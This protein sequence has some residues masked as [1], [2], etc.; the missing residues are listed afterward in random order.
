MVLCLVSAI[1]CI[2]PIISTAAAQGVDN[3]TISQHDTELSTQPKGLGNAEASTAQQVSNTET[4]RSVSIN[5]GDQAVLVPQGVA[6]F[7]V[8][9]MDTVL[10]REIINPIPGS[11][12][13]L[14]FRT[15]PGFEQ[16][17]PL[18]FDVSANA[19]EGFSRLIAGG[20]PG[21]SFQGP[22]V[23]GCEPPDP[24][25]AVGPFH[26]LMGINDQI[27]AADKTTG[28]TLWSVSW[29]SFFSS[30]Q[31]AGAAFTSD[32]KLFYDPVSQRFFATVLFIN[33]SGSKSW[34]MLAVSDSNSV[35]SSGVWT[36]WAFDPTIAAPNFFAD[37]PGFGYD[38]NAVYITSNM[39]SSII[40]VDMAVIPKQQLLDGVAN[41]TFTQLTDIRQSNG[42]RAFTI[43]PAHMFGTGNA[44]FASNTG[45][46][47]STIYFYR[48]NNPLGSPSLTKTSSSVSS[49]S[50]PPDASQSGGGTLIN[51]G[52]DRM[53]NV[54][55][56]N[57]RL[58]CAHNTNSGGLAAAR[59][60]EFDTT[61]WP[62]A[63]STV[64][65]GTI[66]GT[67]VHYYYPTIAVDIFNNAFIGFSR[68][69]SSEFA[70]AWHTSRAAGDPLGTMATPTLDHSGS[71][72]Y[73]GGRWGDYSGTVIDPDGVTFWTMQEFADNTSNNWGNWVSSFAIGAPDLTAPT[74]NP[75]QWEVGG[76]P[77][78]LSTTDIAMQAA[79]ATDDRSGVEYNFS[80]ETGPGA[81]VSSGWQSSVNFTDTGLLANTSYEYDVV[82][83]DMAPTPNVTLPSPLL[84]ATTSIEAPTFVF[85][86]PPAD[87]SVGITAFTPTGTF[88][89][90]AVGSSGLFFEMTPTGG[91]NANVWVQSQSITITGL[92][93]GT[94]YSVRVKA[95]NQL[96]VE[97]AFT[98]PQTVTTTGG[99]TL[100]G[101]V[102]QDGLIN[103]ED[104]AG[105]VRAKLGQMPALGEEPLCADF[106][107]GGD[108]ALD[109]AAFV[110]ALLLN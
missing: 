81:V 54:A 60:Y 94:L 58:W 104:I 5:E 80:R 88:T 78:P 51:T 92:T 2:Q 90:I 47:G 45:R 13:S 63:P 57:N 101:D 21:I 41:P 52:D 95:R 38:G 64:Q 1:W 98:A 103:G 19:D 79:L 59:W 89:N 30:A 15:L 32:P 70:S 22:G 110:S 42:A 108:I 26:V 17:K 82:A 61:F 62:S 31:P 66:T 102:N 76:E 106:G 10:Q 28:A 49:Y 109:N 14:P 4:A 77:A 37:F 93:P 56:R 9:S 44:F 91:V 55:W 24:T 72:H 35:P 43:Q 83:R 97:T 20:T 25:L 53:M 3:P 39:F 33:S 12:R 11:G 6:G 65:S 18:P 50:V 84:G 48:I 107:N 69:S 105:Y 75:M 96:G 36:K 68:S 46:N 99:C 85:F 7:A 87:T 16:S 73:G 23:C 29:E 8:E 71:A 100:A 67:N 27:R 34:W 74:P 40:R 86:D